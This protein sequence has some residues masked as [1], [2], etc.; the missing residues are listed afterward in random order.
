MQTSYM[1]IADTER[2]TRA[3][4]TSRLDR[5]RHSPTCTNVLVDVDFASAQMQTSYT[6]ADTAQLVRPGMIDAM[7]FRFCIRRDANIVHGD[8]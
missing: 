3:D 5:S 2:V 1:M 8:C 4:D 7:T 6:G